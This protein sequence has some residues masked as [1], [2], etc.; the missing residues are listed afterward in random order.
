MEATLAAKTSGLGDTLDYLPDNDFKFT[1]LKSIGLSVYLAAC[2]C[3]YA[4]QSLAFTLELADLE[5]CNINVFQEIAKTRA[6]SGRT[7]GCT[8]GKVL[9]EKRESGAFVTSWKLIKSGGSWEKLA[10]STAV[11]YQELGDK[12]L[13]KKAVM[14][15][16]NRTL[17]LKKCLDSIVERNDPGDCHDS[18]KKVYSVGERSGVD[19]ERTIWLDD[20]GRHVVLGFSYGNSARSD[21][22]P[23]DLEK[24]LGIPAGVKI[25]LHIGREG[26]GGK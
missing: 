1:G 3:I 9:V 15:L 8:K 5:E 25:D 7:K 10:L 20:G 4:S 16:K 12:N 13:L 2:I 14:D 6:W 17:H 22:V 18:A 11:G 26:T 19:M 21:T 24:S 23:A